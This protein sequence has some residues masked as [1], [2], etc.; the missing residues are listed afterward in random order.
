MQ[1][2]WEDLLTKRLS[3]LSNRSWISLPKSPS[4]LRMS[5]RVSPE[6]S[7]RERKPSL[8]STSCNE[9]HQVTLNA[10]N[11]LP[12]LSYYECLQLKIPLKYIGSVKYWWASSAQVNANCN[13][14]LV[15]C[16]LDVGNKSVVSRWDD[17]LVFLSVENVHGDEMDLKQE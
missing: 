9:H 13:S 15:F 16:A 8:M 10:R 7:I 17:V 1:T 14:Y 4:G 3:S 11:T 5:S 12:Y 2:G 6:S